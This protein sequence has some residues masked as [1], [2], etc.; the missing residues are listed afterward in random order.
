MDKEVDPRLTTR[1]FDLLMAACIGWQ[2][3]KKVKAVEREPVY[4]PLWP[5]IN[6]SKPNPAR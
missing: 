5:T 6:Q 3:N 2:M 1:H 4:D